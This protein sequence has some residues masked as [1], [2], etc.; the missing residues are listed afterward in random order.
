MLKIEILQKLT[1][2]VKSG[3]SKADIERGADIPKNSLSSVLTGV[4]EMPNKWVEKF[5][6]YF[7]KLEVKPTGIPLPAD[8]VEVEKVTAIRSHGFHDITCSADPAKPMGCEGCSCAMYKRAKQ[9]EKE[10]DELLEKIKG[11]EGDANTWRLRM[12]QT[13]E[14]IKNSPPAITTTNAKP[15]ELSPFLKSR[16]A[17]KNGQK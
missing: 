17:L 15:K 4:K 14:A 11:L 8:Y 10:R 9:A 1:D 5:G 2:L 3:T 16:Q 7:E 13:S 12:A 6:G